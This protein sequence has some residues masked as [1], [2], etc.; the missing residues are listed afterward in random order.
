[1]VVEKVVNLASAFRGTP[2]EELC[3]EGAGGSGVAMA[4]SNPF[5]TL[6]VLFAI[7][8]LEDHLMEE[9]STLERFGQA[10]LLELLGWPLAYSAVLLVEN[11]E[12]LSHD[13]VIPR[14]WGIPATEC[15]RCL[16]RN[17]KNRIGENDRFPRSSRHLLVTQKV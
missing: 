3:A 11:I 13:P 4:R 9:I 7:V 15:P 6:Q 16:R 1:M 14:I 2:P 10:A 8:G 12:W 5:E 17:L